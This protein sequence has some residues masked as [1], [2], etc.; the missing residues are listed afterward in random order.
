M[1]RRRGTKKKATATLPGSAA[2]ASTRSQ[3]LVGV[4]AASIGCALIACWNGYAATR[5]VATG[6]RVRK[7]GERF[8][9]LPPVASAPGV[10]RFHVPVRMAYPQAHVVDA[11]VVAVDNFLPLDL[12]ERWRDRMDQQWTS[13]HSQGNFEQLDPADTRG[14]L[15]TTND[16]NSKSRGNAN[17][18]NRSMQ[19]ERM[20]QAGRFA[21]SK[22][23]LAPEHALVH[24]MQAHLASKE[25]RAKVQALVGSKDL[26]D[27]MADI[28]V[29]QFV[30]SN[31]L[32]F[33]ENL[34]ENTDGGPEQPHPPPTFSRGG[35]LLPS[36]Y[37]S[38]RSS[39]D[40]I[41]F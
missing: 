1:T 39:D 24:E 21:Y 4:I 22:W 30:K 36:I 29:T 20:R 18:V 40:V 19:S 25:T 9:L 28:F 37:A 3:V 33:T 34:L 32:G 14:W 8:T 11:E 15:Y 6:S 17:I 31:L 2:A 5:D 38:G 7:Q 27:G 12:A 41:A 23:E 13:E 10:R 26:N 16:A 35:S